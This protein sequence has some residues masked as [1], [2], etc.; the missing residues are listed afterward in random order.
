MAQRLPTSTPLAGVGA[1]LDDV[2]REAGVSLAT[3]DRAM[4]RRPGV[5]RHAQQRVEAALLRLAEAAG[6]PQPPQPRNGDWLLCFLLPEGPNAFVEQLRESLQA[7]A[8]WLRERHAQVDIRTTSAFSP[9]AA[10]AAVRRLRGQYDAVVLMLQDHPQVREAVER[11]AADGTGVV[12]LVSDLGTRARCHFVGI[13]NRAAG[14]TAATLLGRFIGARSGPVGI[15]L[16]SHALNDHAD[17]LAGFR[18]AMEAEHPHLPLLP[19]LECQD[20]AESAHALLMQLLA[21]QPGLAGLYSIGAGNAGIHTA[22]LQSGAAGRVAWVC[23]E[24]TPQSRAALT[25]GTACAVVGQPAA[26][27]AR[28]ACERALARLTR[29]RDTVSAEP[30]RIEIYLKDNLP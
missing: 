8:P 28:L 23:H 15:L 26:Q 27:Q 18:Q 22:L 29:Q 25:D 21:E 16:G 3:V 6:A 5:S 4:H 20:R 17:R 14:R 1:T 12:T 24:L 13:D 7:L 19:P 10:A 11:M 30:L 2:A 9:A